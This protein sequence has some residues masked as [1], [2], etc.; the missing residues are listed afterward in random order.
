MPLLHRLETVNK[1]NDRWRQFFEKRAL[2]LAIEPFVETNDCVFT[3][4]SCFAREIRFA[5]AELG[6]LVSPRFET[7]H[8]DM[9]EQR[10]DQLP[11][12]QHLNYYN[13]FTIRQEFE[14]FAGI[15]KQADDDYWTVKRNLFGR[16]LSY[17]DPYK[18]LTFGSDP[19][20]LL[21]AVSQ[22]N[23]VIDSGISNASVFF[24]TF[25]MTEVFKKKNNGLIACQKP[26]YLGGGGSAETIFHASRFAE[27]YEN[28]EKVREIIKANNPQAR[29][30][31]TVS[32]VPLERTFSGNDIV[33]AN[34]A[35]KSMLRACLQEFSD[36]HNDVT[37]FPAYEIVSLIGE[38]A[39]ETRDLRHVDRKIVNIIMRGFVSAHVQSSTV[40]RSK[41]LPK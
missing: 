37:Y 34:M 28:L 4:G 30:I 40:S 24:F 39:F 10:V 7:I 21:L 36:N 6:V 25:G 1:L 26:A 8:L 41:K 2:S 3:M 38:A 29:L 35:G 12:E 11:Q 20:K 23:R 19:E 5:L 27:N 33:V 32:P 17:Q 14:R 15:W 31:V 16:S 9:T 13:T 22:V 18:R